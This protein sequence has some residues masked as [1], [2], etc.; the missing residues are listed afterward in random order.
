M[1]EGDTGPPWHALPDEEV[2]TAIRSSP[3]G[4]SAAE[5]EARLSAYGKN[6]LPTR[7]PPSVFQV[8]FRQFKSPLIFILIVAGGIS[9]L[10]GE[11]T[12]ALFIFAVI[13]LNALL[14][15]VQEWKAEQSAAA[16]RA[17]LR[18]TAHVRRDG[19][20]KGISAEDV[21]PGDIVLLEPGSRVPA[22]LRIF[23][24]HVLSVDESLLSGESVPA[25]KV[26]GPVDAD[27]PLMGRKNMAYAGSTAIS[28][29]GCGVVVATGRET[30]VGK[31]AASISA[32]E[33]T[34]P[35]LLIRMEQFSKWVGVLVVGA[36]ALLAVAALL[37][38]I[39]AI[40]VFFMAVALAVSAI[41][42]GLPVAITV[43]LSL[44]VSRIARRNVVV[45]NLAAVEGLGSC[46]C[47]A[48][49]KTGTLTVNE[50]TL[51]LI[52]L[53]D[54]D[55]YTVLGEGYRGEGRVTD[56]AGMPPEEEEFVRLQEMVRT[57]MICN[58][59]VLERKDGEW[60]HFGDAIDVAFLACGYKLRLSPETVRAEVASLAEIPFEPERRYAAT[61]Y[62]VGGSVKVAF[63]GAPEVVVPRCPEAPPGTA[64]MAAHL[65]AAGYRV[66]GVAH[67]E[68]AGG[69]DLP[70]DEEDIPPLKFLGMACFI[71]PLRHDAAAAVEISRQA[72]IRVVMV[73]GDHPATALAIARDLGIASSRTDLVTGEELDGAR[74][75]DG[76]HFRD[77]VKNG[78]VFSRVAPL[79]KSEIVAALQD[80]GHFV[81]V[82]GDGANDAP[83]LRRANIGVAM[84]SGTD[85]A[86]D[87]ASIIITDDA[88]SSIVTG[89]TG[90]RGTYDNI[91]KVT[92]LLI[93]TGAAEV[94]LFTLALLAGLSIPLLAVQLLWL[95]LVTN[96]IQD[97]ALAFE[98]GEPDVMG[99][100][101]RPPEE[102]IFNRQM[103]EQ[104]LVSGGYIGAT[105]FLL[106]AWLLSSGWTDE[107]ARNVLL[108]FMVFM[109]NAHAF[110][111]RSERRSIFRVP[112]SANPFLV[113]GVVAAQGIHLL[114]MQ[115]PLMQGVL[116]VAPVS[117][118]IWLSLLAV[119]LSL[120]LVMEGYKYMRR[121]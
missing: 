59:A 16:L 30:E 118:S 38:G 81:A 29:R 93:S 52:M 83:A 49:D 20:E 32:M 14:G 56:T 96:G 107:A 91:R 100:R 82:T 72:G 2:L 84:G 101:P 71:D 28:G 6:A 41:P 90:G 66:I 61:L 65:A 77:L 47:I 48:S 40:E 114:A 115:V 109:E 43:A 21:V 10:I 103:V 45:R 63:K 12:D 111:C 36:S 113:V 85:L 99:R 68:I 80:N 70:F 18:I 86:K 33:V 87:T 120:V 64:E 95:N 8:F 121:W 37:Q 75:A 88:F 53:P 39:P 110:N 108:L 11:T 69:V 79:Q 27:I 74:G 23:Q 78:Q 1:P 104:T 76:D 92:Y 13:F 102:G 55:R 116:G 73:T 3:H 15:M 22:D 50:Q 67:G 46:T 34:K 117:F 112:L 60:T 105:A 24:E 119:A 4:L 58:E 19:T 9:L 98:K 97:V 26:T 54:G 62:R 44:G 57:S 25:G 42:E 17:L 89:I 7:A 106:W 31:I 51:T 5:A 94:L 35:P